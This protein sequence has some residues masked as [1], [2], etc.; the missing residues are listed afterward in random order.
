MDASRTFP[1]DDLETTFL[2]LRPELVRR[3]RSIDPGGDPDDVVQEVWLRLRAVRAPV[4]NPR[5]YLMRM[6][7]SVVLDRRRSRNRSAARDGSWAAAQHP[8]GK[9]TVPPDAENLLMARER[10]AAI[11]QRLSAV[12]E[13][14]NTIFRRYR[15]RGEPQ[16]QIADDLGMALRTVEKHLHRAYA[17][18]HQ[19]RGDQDD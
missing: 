11:N 16:R 15:F 4:D 14:A 13:P 5:A 3:A 9:D 7:Y 17:A 2:A 8:G 12:G 18:I 10:L 6:V 19:L 1:P